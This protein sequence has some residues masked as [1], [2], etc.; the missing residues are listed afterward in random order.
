[1]LRAQRDEV[2]RFYDE[3]LRAGGEPAPIRTQRLALLRDEIDGAIR[4]GDP[5]PLLVTRG[6]DGRTGVAVSELSTF[7]GP[8][9]VNPI[10]VYEGWMYRVFPPH[11]RQAAWNSFNAGEFLFGRSRWSLV[12]L[13]IVAGTLVYLAL[14]LAARRT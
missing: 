3:T 8:V 9:S 10:G 14:R 6:A 12:P 4:S 1:L 11:S 13:L 7:V 2:L 5:A